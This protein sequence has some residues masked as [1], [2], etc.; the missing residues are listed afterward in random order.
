MSFSSL[1]IARTRKG[2]GLAA[3]ATDEGVKMQA[4]LNDELLSA[5]GFLRSWTPQ[6]FGYGHLFFARTSVHPMRRIREFVLRVWRRRILDKVWLEY[7]LADTSKRG[8]N[9]GFSISMESGNDLLLSRG[10]IF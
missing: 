2:S 5:L 4:E 1:D 8:P 3:L 9:F 7:S 10:I 6:S